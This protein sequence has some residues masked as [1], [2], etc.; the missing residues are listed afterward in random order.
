MDLG[1]VTD[2]NRAMELSAFITSKANSFG[3]VVGRWYDGQV[4]EI[5]IVKQDQRG[6]G[7]REKQVKIVGLTKILHVQDRCSEQSY[8]QTLAGHFITKDFGGYNLTYS[9]Y[10]RPCPPKYDCLPKTLSFDCV[11]TEAW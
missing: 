2:L 11:I 5:K 3:P 1:M 9:Q 4:D 7:G 6:K 10:E 8:Y